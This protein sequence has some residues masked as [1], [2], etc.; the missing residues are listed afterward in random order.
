MTGVLIPAAARVRMA[1]RRLGARFD[2]HQ[3][4]DSH[5]RWTDGMPEVIS[6]LDISLGGRPGILESRAGDRLN[7]QVGGAEVDMDREYGGAGL[8]SV[9]RHRVGTQDVLDTDYQSQLR[10][11]FDDEGSGAE[12]DFVGQDVTM[13]LTE[14]DLDGMQRAFERATTAKRI[15]VVSGPVD[16]FLA[17]RAFG[18]R[19]KV[20]GGDEPVT[21]EFDAPS[22]KKL[23]DARN[24]I[25]E[26]FDEFG[27]FG[28]KGAD[29][30]DVTVHTNMGDMLVSRTAE[31]DGAD[32]WVS[33]AALERD[34]WYVTYTGADQDPFREAVYDL[35][36]VASV[37]GFYHY[38]AKPGSHRS[39]SGKVIEGTPM[40]LTSRAD[41]ATARAQAFRDGQLQRAD[42]PRQRRSDE[43]GG[44]GRVRAPLTDPQVREP[45]TD[46]LIEFVGHASVTERAYDMWDWYGEYS[47]VIS[48]S[49]FDTTL[50][51]GDLDVPLV[52]GHDQLRRI[53]RT[54]NGTLDLSMDDDGL[55]VAARLDPA[56]ADV[57]YIV[58][59]LRARLVDEMSFAFRIVRGTWS[60]DYTEYRIDEVDLHRGD[61][62]IVGY[63]ANPNTDAGVRA[64][65]ARP[66]SGARAR[67]LL[68]LAIAR[69]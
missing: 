15:E 11:R 26:G 68:E 57:A 53:A 65:P 63:G 59:K 5:G 36:Q 1:R 54:L 24:V 38:S 29:V 25:D 12:L 34:D 49:A 33:V 47:E 42:R 31:G 61:T 62:A 64:A 27:Q 9:L 40:L 20:E 23:G 14:A 69:G 56:D 7:L 30:T 44:R 60:P 51:R 8:L 32:L 17:D 35:E 39:R 21:M 58:P 16:V 52:L 45:G 18:I 6:A 19:A 46:G 22:W 37:E 55:L 2:P 10:F 3:P 4:R 28:P 13:R 67:A 48:A 66:G 43:H 41:A 50:A